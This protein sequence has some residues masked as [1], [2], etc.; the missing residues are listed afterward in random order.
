MKTAV[1][2]TLIV[3]GAAIVA[4]PALS[5]AWRAWMMTRLMEHGAT[6]VTLEGRMEDLYRFGCWALGA[7]M[8]GVAILSALMPGADVRSSRVTANAV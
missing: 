6:S 5:D 8:I 2:V 1:I 7:A 3:V 4:L